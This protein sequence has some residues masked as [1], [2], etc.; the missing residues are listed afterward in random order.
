[1]PDL[2]RAVLIVDDFGHVSAGRS[3]LGQP[4]DLGAEVEPVQ[5]GRHLGL[6]A[7]RALGE[8][9]LDLVGG[10]ELDEFGG[11][12]AMGMGKV[13]GGGRGQ[14]IEMLRAARSSMRLTGADHG[15]R[16]LQRL[17]VKD[18]A[19]LG[20]LEVFRHAGERRLAGTLQE[21]EDRLLAPVH[22]ESLSN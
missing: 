15:A 20:H 14:A 10:H 22:K 6:A 13:L 5:L 1:M 12:L 17:E 16:L 19:L 7:R 9:A 4:V 8:T 21:L 18:G 3:Q 11:Q 2:E